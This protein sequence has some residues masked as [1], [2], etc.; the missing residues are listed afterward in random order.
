MSLKDLRHKIFPHKSPAADTQGTVYFS[1]P[2]YRKNLHYTVQPKPSKGSD[3]VKMMNDYILKHHPNDSGIIYCLSKKVT[4]FVPLRFL[5]SKYFSSKD[6]ESVA[7]DLRKLSGGKIKTGVYHADRHD[8]EKEGL[9]KSWRRGD[10]KVVCATIGSSR[11][12]YH[13]TELRVSSQRLV[14]EL[15]KGMCASSCI[16]PYVLCLYHVSPDSRWIH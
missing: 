15:T 8:S 12:F 5:S 10:I 7:E 11:P 1:S 13:R 16:I 4:L 9:H 2:L 6:A 14:W 3:V